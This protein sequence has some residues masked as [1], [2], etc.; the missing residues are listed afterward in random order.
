MPRLPLA[1]L[2]PLALS[3]WPLAS[4][5][6]PL[7]QGS[8]AAP[9]FAEP[10]ISPDRSEIAFASGGDIWT[11]PAQ[12]GDARL[13]VAHA[14][15]ES[16][17]VYSPDGAQLAFVSDRTGN[18]DIYVL[19]L[20]RGTLHR[21]TYDDVP[22]Q[23]NAWSRDGEWL[24]FS[25]TS[26]DISGMHDV[27]RVRATGGT[28]MRVAGDRYASEFWA[29]PAPDGQ[30]IAIAFSTCAMARHGQSP[31]GSWKRSSPVTSSWYAS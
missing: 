3:L 11:V 8:G 21:V 4:G 17:P 7:A 25:S 22:E 30:S 1:L 9:A 16:Q 6:W 15:D 12:G 14:A 28:P 23:L 27:F 18:G 29:A 5:L 2:A 31:H 26:R 19:D 13:L 20:R 24:Y 10:S